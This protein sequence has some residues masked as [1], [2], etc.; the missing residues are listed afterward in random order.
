M[1]AFLAL[2]GWETDYITVRIKVPHNV[3]L[4][5]LIN[6]LEILSVKIKN[7]DN[8]VKTKVTDLQLLV[9]KTRQNKSKIT[10][11]NCIGQLYN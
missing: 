9:G 7:F 4:F 2:A 5:S 6:L 8:P 10:D 3:V 1:Y 11:C